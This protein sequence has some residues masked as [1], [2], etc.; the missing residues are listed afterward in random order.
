MDQ[1][2]ACDDQAG[3]KPCQIH[4]PVEAVGKSPRRNLKCET[5]QHRGEHNESDCRAVV[6]SP[7]HPC[8]NERVERAD[9]QSAY[10]RAVNCDGGFPREPAVEKRRGDNDLRLLRT[11]QAYQRESHRKDSDDDVE[12]RCPLDIDLAYQDLADCQCDIDSD[13]V[14]GKSATTVRWRSLGIQPTL[15]GNE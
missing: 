11:G 10:R 5:S 6:A 2:N 14:D 1:C 13:P 12:G 7:L 9:N 4:A 15:G 3:T 8:R